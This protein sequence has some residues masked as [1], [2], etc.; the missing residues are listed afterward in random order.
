MARRGCYGV[1]RDPWCYAQSGVVPEWRC[2]RRDLLCVLYV[3]RAWCEREDFE[4]AL[5]SRQAFRAKNLERASIIMGMTSAMLQF[6][7]AM[8]PPNR[9]ANEV[10]RALDADHPPTD[11]RLVQWRS[12]RIESLGEKVGARLDSNTQYCD[13]A[14]KLHAEEKGEAMLWWP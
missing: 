6:C 5:H 1:M 3:G 11:E 4:C 2:E 10:S 7:R 13:D 14:L 12:D 8:G 9:H